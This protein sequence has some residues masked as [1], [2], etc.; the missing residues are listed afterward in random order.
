MLKI[1]PPGKKLKNLRI[2]VPGS[3]S[4]TNRALLLA[5]L[6]KGT[7]TLVNPLYSEDTKVMIQALEQMGVR[8]QKD[9]TRLIIRGKEGQF[10][11]PSGPFM[12]ENA[13][14]AVRSL[15]AVLATQP[16]PSTI[17]GNK[18]MQE[19]PIQ[20]LVNAL[21]LLNITIKSRNGYP[22]IT[23]QGPLMGGDTTIAGNVSSQYLSALL[24][25]AP[26][27][28]QTV[29]IHVKGHLTSLPY[30]HMTL[31]IMEK[32]GVNVHNKNNTTF[33]VEPQTYQATTYQIE[34]DASS[35]SYPLGLAALHGN[36]ITITNISKNSKQADLEFIEILKKMGC[37]VTMSQKSIAVQ[38][39][40]QLQPLRTI[41]LNKM[42]DA[43]MTVAVLC[44][45]A[46]GKSKL[47][48]LANLRVKETDRL[49]ALTTELQRIGVQATTGKD[50]ITIHGDPESIHGGV[51]DTYND[52]R[53]AMCFALAG[54]KIPNIRI[55]NPN[56]VQKTYPTFWEELTHWGIYAKKESVPK[57]P[58]LILAGL[59]GSGKSSVGKKAAFRLGYKFIDTDEYIVRQEGKSIPE[60]IKS[61]GWSFFRK[62]EARTA[63]ELSKHQKTV[64][65]TG[66][67]MF[68]NSQNIKTLKES[69]FIALLHGDPST[70]ARRIQKDPNRPSLTNQS[71]VAK[72]LRQLWKERRESYFTAAD[73][74]ISANQQNTDKNTAIN[75]NVKKTLQEFHR[76][77]GH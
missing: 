35:A 16:F 23:L 9:K 3:K 67:G 66:G 47:T 25:A 22:P 4:Y 62:L 50:C 21:Q 37:G 53:V 54:S 29:T 55:A 59:R 31:D 68:I 57:Y 11:A 58:N 73:F 28:Q 60:M 72:E 39:P 46:K 10:K 45:F 56:C 51:I 63:K 2:T 7:S 19:R 36:K 70:F 43:A 8:I 17:T 13:G 12:L 40:R 26:L 15:T 42:P 6:A 76:I 44:G 32:F 41:N 75:E 1:I 64:I 27:A 69:G 5:S 18:R 33:T 20:D 24:M 30:V 61:K 77:Q 38:G 65:A 52:H 49:K 71:T 14:T 74:V 48:G 34:G